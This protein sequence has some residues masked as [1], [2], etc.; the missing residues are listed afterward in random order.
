[1][2]N[3]SYEEMAAVLDCDVSLLTRRFAQVIKR[4]R[5][6]GKQSLKRQMWTQAMGLRQVDRNGRPMK[7]EYGIPQYG[8]KPNITMQI[9]LSKNML[10]YADKVDFVEENVE[11][12]YPEPTCKAKTDEPG[13]Y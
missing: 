5:G 13:E 4:G 10:G 12:T 6:I 9:F 2:I 7:D 1:M 8:M 3:C 11:L